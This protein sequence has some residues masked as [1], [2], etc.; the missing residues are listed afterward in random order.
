[1][2]ELTPDQESRERAEFEEYRAHTMRYRFANQVLLGVGGATVFG[3]VASVVS[4][5]LGTITSV[6]GASVAATIAAAPIA[7]ASLAVLAVVGIG[8]IYLGSTYLTKN[9]M[10]DQDYQAKKIGVATRVPGQ[11]ID[12][13]PPREPQPGLPGGLAAQTDQREKG[14][15]VAATAVAAPTANWTN[16]ITPKADMALAAP[17]AAAQS[18]IERATGDGAPVQAAQRA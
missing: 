4:S 18:W 9:I 17:R 16:K 6:A 10:L 14:E 7:C 5:L 11:T 8:C 1:M 12:L 15:D 3:L 13:T 2:A